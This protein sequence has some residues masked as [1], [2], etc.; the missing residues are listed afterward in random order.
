MMTAFVLAFLCLNAAG[1]FCLS[2]C[3]GF[4]TTATASDD[5]HLSEHCKSMKREAV[6]ADNERTKATAIEP[7]CCMLPVAMLAVPLERSVTFYAA[8]APIAVPAD[9]SYA[10]TAVTASHFNSTQQPVYRPPP[11]DRR[12]DRQLNCVIRI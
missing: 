6:A 2:L 4:T 10:Y 3:A 8:D 9:V 5:S 7:S 1:A 11:L 12:I